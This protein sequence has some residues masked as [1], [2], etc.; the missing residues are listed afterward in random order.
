MVTR[1]IISGCYKEYRLIDKGI[2]YLAI[3][4]ELLNDI[5]SNLAYEI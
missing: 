5:K 2:S 3:S 1:T 4:E